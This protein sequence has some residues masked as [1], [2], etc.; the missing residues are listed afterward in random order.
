MGGRTF[1]VLMTAL[2]MNE[3][4]KSLDRAHSLHPE[5]TTLGDFRADLDLIAAETEALRH[6]RR[7]I[8]PH[9]AIASLYPN[10]GELLSWKLPK[11]ERRSRTNN[12]RPRVVFPASTVGRKGCYELRE[13]LRGLDVSV[14]TLGPTIEGD[15]FWKGFKIETG[16][17]WLKTADLVVLPAFVEHKPRRLLIAAANGVPVVASTACGVGNVEGIETV[18]PGDV[19]ELRE[20]V[21]SALA[22][23][24]AV[25]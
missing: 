14:V 3:L 6:A 1:D 20:S 10:R 2:P 24:R 17:D 16:I 11:T 5:S 22:G 7:I 4:Q 21:V 15:D 8:T 12:I 9:T 19:V 18:K 13:A 25:V 23:L